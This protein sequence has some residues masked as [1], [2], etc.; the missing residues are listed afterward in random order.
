M[1]SIRRRLRQLFR[2][3]SNS[4]PTATPA[5][6]IKRLSWRPRQFRKGKTV[7]KPPANTT[8]D[9]YDRAEESDSAKDPNAAVKGTELQLL[10]LPL[11]IRSNPFSKATFSASS[12]RPSEP[13]ETQVE[14]ATAFKFLDLRTHTDAKPRHCLRHFTDPC[15]SLS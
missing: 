4:S 7:A 9:V 2:R 8:H 10:E 6:K 15:I 5:P 14:H 3:D 11:D 12:K 13:V 1:G